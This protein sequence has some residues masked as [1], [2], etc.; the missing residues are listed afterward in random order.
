[1]IAPWST[2]G[3]KYSDWVEVG[4]GCALTPVPGVDSNLFKMRCKDT[5]GVEHDWTDQDCWYY[6]AIQ[7][8][9]N[10]SNMQDQPINYDIRN[11]QH[12]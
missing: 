1:M 11:I 6:S 2:D 12:N 4:R 9:S 3:S 5:S 10:R 8:R 7:F